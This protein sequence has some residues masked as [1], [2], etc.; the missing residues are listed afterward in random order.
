M[1]KTHWQINIT[2]GHRLEDH[3]R[4]GKQHTHNFKVEVEIYSVKLNGR[5]G[6]L[7]DQSDVESIVR[8]YERIEI[9]KSIEELA[10]E[11]YTKTED[12]LIHKEYHWDEMRIR[13]TMD[14]NTTTEYTL[15]EE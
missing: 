6:Q 8:H 1:H 3:P 10:K 11:I 2:A 14:E 9:Q 15:I 13:I 12:L 5:Y 4:C 7:L